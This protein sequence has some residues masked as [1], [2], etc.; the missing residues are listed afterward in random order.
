MSNQAS[1]RTLSYIVATLLAG[2]CVA[3][4]ATEFSGRGVYPFASASGCPLAELAGNA[5]Q[6]NR[7][8][9]DNADTRATLDP[10]EQ[11]IHFY[12]TRKYDKKTIVGDVLLQGTGVSADGQRI[13]LSFHLVL[14]KSGQKWSMS[15]HT[16]APV[17]GDFSDVKIDPY[18]V[19]VTEPEGSRVMLVPAKISETLARP[20][21]ASRLASELVQVRDNRA[22]G[23]RDADIT[24]AVG[25]GKLSKSVMRA[26]L[27]SDPLSAG[28]ANTLLTQGNWA[29]EL[30]ALTG[31]IPDNVA[32]REL[33]L[34]GLGGQPLL[35][36]L[37][38]RGFK[39]HEKLT[40]G[41]VNGK[42]YLRYGDRQQAFPGADAA[43]RAFLQ[44]SFIG[45]VL[46]WQQLH[47]DTGA[48]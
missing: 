20:G 32:Q 7:L 9:L 13:P 12:N 34:F 42:G 28:N 19:V 18:Q 33:F 2:S 14:S 3:A 23:A 16:H 39:K 41:A 8:A 11:L 25:P 36:P 22:A 37:L 29:F 48:R 30:E 31:Q 1:S 46:G 4:G 44:Y 43:A 27:H 38:D 47:G 40:V 17:H 21:L 45:L 5:E 24:I 15:K 35:K 6:C 10:A 26:R